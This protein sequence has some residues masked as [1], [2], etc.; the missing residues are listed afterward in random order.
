[1]SSSDESTRN[2]VSPASPSSKKQQKNNEDV[3]RDRVVTKN[4]SGG[5]QPCL[6][7]CKIDDYGRKYLETGLVSQIGQVWSGI[8]SVLAFRLQQFA[9]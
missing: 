2:V 1:M 6:T 9:F 8:K 3:S 5:R 4:N 7:S